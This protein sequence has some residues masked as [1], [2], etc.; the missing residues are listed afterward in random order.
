MP[1]R[2]RTSYTTPDSQTAADKMAIDQLV[3][4]SPALPMAAQGTN[5]PFQYEILARMPAGL[6]PSIWAPQTQRSIKVSLC[7]PDA[8]EE[9][10]LTLDKIS[11]SKLEFLP[12]T[13]FLKHSPFHT[14]ILLPCGHGFHAMALIYHWCKSTMLCPCCRA[15]IKR[16]ASIDCLPEHFRQEMESRV[17]TTLREEEEEEV[18]T[19]TVA[20]IAMLQT[21]IVFENWGLMGNL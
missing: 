15:G 20:F 21:T 2:A 5:R 10:P 17:A 3:R 16:R 4:D 11:E 18:S 13:T 14:K 12:S 9:C 19:D 6:L 8:D 1:K 7:V